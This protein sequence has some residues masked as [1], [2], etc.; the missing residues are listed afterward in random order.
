MRQDFRVALP[1]AWKQTYDLVHWEQQPV[2]AAYL[3]AWLQL[4]ERMLAPFAWEEISVTPG[5]RE[6]ALRH[7]MIFGLQAMDAVHL[8]CAEAIGVVDFASFD[9]GFRRVDSLILWN[10]HIHG[11]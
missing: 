7:M 4:V 9:R 10:D 3:M 11:H 8:A 2:R 5:V 6:R 1:Q